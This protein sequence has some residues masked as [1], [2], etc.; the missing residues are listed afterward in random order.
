MAYV[1]QNAHALVVTPIVK[2]QFEGIGLS[3]RDFAEHVTG[4]ITAPIRQAEA[5]CPKPVGLGHD[6][7]AIKN[8]GAEM[9]VSAE[10][11]T[12]EMTVP[13]GNIAKRTD[14]R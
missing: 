12:S 4:D 10:E 8:N 5:R 13:T 14:R 7:R 11:S 1:G 9:R 2:D 6:L 3:R